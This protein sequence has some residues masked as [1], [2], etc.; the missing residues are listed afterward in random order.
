MYVQL[1]IFIPLQLTSTSTGMREGSDRPPVSRPY[2]AGA[3]TKGKLLTTPSRLL[4][5]ILP[6]TTRDQNTDRKDVEPL[7]LLVHPQ[8]PLSYLERLIQSELPFTK[9]EKG[10]EVPP[11]VEFSAV[12]PGLDEDHEG[13]E[14]GLTGMKSSMDKQEE[15]RDSEGVVGET[16]GNKSDVQDLG[17]SNTPESTSSPPFI[18]WSKSTELGDFIRSAAASRHANEFAIS[19]S[20][21]PKPLTVGVP[22]FSDR[23]YYLRTRLRKKSSE[24]AA[25]AGLKR[26]CDLAAHASAQRVAYAGFAGMVGWGA[27]VWWLTFMTSL[28]WDV[29]EPV[30]YLVGL[31]GII[32]GYAWFLYN[33]REASYAAA[34]NVTVSKR[35]NKLYELRG[36]DL[37]RWEWLVDECKGLRDEIRRIASEY[38]VEW[39]E[40]KDAKDENVVNALKEYG[41]GSGVDEGKPAD[42]K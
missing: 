40:T 29:M 32:G 8:Q 36:F 35:Q 11:R 20:N 1:Y 14:V 31:V 12:D 27:M 25:M 16:S 42:E 22:S 6:L 18:R 13:R 41:D 21:A 33:R 2:D 28:G 7:A 10:R 24:I 39:E 5:L 19:I 23:T 3:M 37:R 38:D 34:M 17:R 30:T 4:K 15:A 26:E 9:D